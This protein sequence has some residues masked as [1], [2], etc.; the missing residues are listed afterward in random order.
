[1]GFTFPLIERLDQ[2]LQIILQNPP[3][4]DQFYCWRPEEVSCASLSPIIHDCNLSRRI[5]RKVP[6]D[7][8]RGHGVKIG[9]DALWIKNTLLFGLIH[10]S[11]LLHFEPIGVSP[12]CL[13]RIKSIKHFPID[14]H[15]FALRIFYI[16][17]IQLHLEFNEAIQQRR[18]SDLHHRILFG[19]GIYK[20]YGPLLYERTFLKNNVFGYTRELSAARNLR[21]EYKS[22]LGLVINRIVLSLSF[23]YLRSFVVF[24]PHSECLRQILLCI[25]QINHH[26]VFRGESCEC[27]RSVKFVILTL[28]LLIQGFYNLDVF[29]PTRRNLDTQKHLKVWKFLWWSAIRVRKVLLL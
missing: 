21:Y 23:V 17:S 6:H 26:L 16:D 14:C 12:E 15:V 4:L 2:P 10:N 29:H 8:C 22:S 7:N 18:V 11:A 1:M 9:W 13:V 28:R 27:Q 3:I 25:F 19:D 5:A 24:E 20:F